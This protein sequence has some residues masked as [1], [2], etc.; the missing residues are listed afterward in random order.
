[1]KKLLL[2]ASLFILVVSCKTG[3]RAFEKGDYE[4]AVL[5][6]VERLR[7]DA[8]NKDASSILPVA[9][10]LSL[11]TRLS[12]INSLKGS[13]DPYRFEALAKNYELLNNLADN[14]QRCPACLQLTKPVRYDA[15]LRNAR[16]EVV[17]FRLISAKA[18]LKNKENR[19]VAIAAYQDLEVAEAYDRN[20]QE[21]LSLK[22]QALD[23]ATLRVVVQP[24]YGR[25]NL[26]FG[27]MEVMNQRLVDY[28]HNTNINRFVRFY[29]P[30][31]AHNLNLAVVDHEIELG[32]TYFSPARNTNTETYTL[33]LDSI[34]VESSR[35]GKV[36]YIDAE[37]TV[38]EHFVEYS[39][40]A[41]LAI[42]I[43][44]D[45]QTNPLRTEVLSHGFI[46]GDHWATY[47]GDKRA[48][49]KEAQA[50]VNKRPQKQPTP[51]F[52]FQA[53]SEP[54]YEDAVRFLRR[55]YAN[56]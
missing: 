40:N 17:A 53:T 39:S 5:Q 9:Y 33:Q 2:L 32:V 22:S 15:E 4:K 36:R 18:K 8:D 13:L 50:L 52:L 19:T 27:Y 34:P 12:Q 42:F 10:K 21:I 14:I 30:Q 45:N 49:T 46:W 41:N 1:M 48:L 25:N 44:S 31:E 43:R 51:D 6:A 37:A 38:I 23:Y 54:L 3:K 11:E 55:Y 56:Y 35:N 28:L 29:T 47:R 20:N 24:L 16:Q 26:S 7:D